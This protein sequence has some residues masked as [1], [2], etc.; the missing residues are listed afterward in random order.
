MVCRK[1]QYLQPLPPSTVDVAHSTQA[2]ATN[3]RL[4]AR[5]EANPRLQVYSIT[6]SH[7]TQL[8]HH[9]SNHVH[10]NKYPPSNASRE[11]SSYSH[12]SISADAIQIGVYIVH[13]RHMQ[14]F[15]I[16]KSDDRHSPL[17]H[18]ASPHSIAGLHM[19]FQFTA[20]HQHKVPVT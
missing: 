10:G 7:L 1:E 8:N 19:V 16:G 17:V 15:G 4:T 18:I 2:P 3:R 14:I 20:S 5:L 11:A 9:R 13:S 6:D 12:G